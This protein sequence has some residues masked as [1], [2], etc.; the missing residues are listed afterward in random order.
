MFE[1]LFFNLKQNGGWCCLIK[2]APQERTNSHKT[3]ENTV[4]LFSCRLKLFVLHLI[5]PDNL[6][7]FSVHTLCKSDENSSQQL[8]QCLMP[9]ILLVLYKTKSSARLRAKRDDKN[10]P[11]N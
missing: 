2:Y 10:G 8:Q 4:H 7:L 6:N 11:R 5:Q 1:C 9:D 3:A